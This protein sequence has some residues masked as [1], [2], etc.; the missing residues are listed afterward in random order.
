MGPGVVFLLFDHS[1][2]GR[3]VILQCVT[4]VEPLLQ[5]VSHTI[6]YQ[7]NIPPLVPKFVLRAE[8]IQVQY[9]LTSYY[10][11]HVVIQGSWLSLKGSIALM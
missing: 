4:P 9:A 8:C 11:C 6:F 10:R 1:F 5:W 2:L 3:G 7:S